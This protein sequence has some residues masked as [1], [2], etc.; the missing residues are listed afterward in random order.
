MLRA[1]FSNIWKKARRNYNNKS[2][3]AFVIRGDFKS[4]GPNEF[5]PEI[6]I[7]MGP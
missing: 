4:R 7:L 2:Q 3:Q 5:F 6:K 1:R